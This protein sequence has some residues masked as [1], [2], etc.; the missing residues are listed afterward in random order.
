M[1]DYGII[2]IELQFINSLDFYELKFFKFSIFYQNLSV[3]Y[4]EQWQ[5]FSRT[6]TFE[7]FN[8]DQ[9]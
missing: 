4:W 5:R 8:K 1:I 9:S 7:T 6:F 2:L 3:K